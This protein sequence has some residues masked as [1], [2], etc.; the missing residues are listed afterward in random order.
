MQSYLGGTASKGCCGVPPWDCPGTHGQLLCLP[1]PDRVDV[2]KEADEARSGRAPEPVG[3]GTPA[4]GL[5]SV[6][7]SIADRRFSVRPARGHLC[8]Q[9]GPH[10]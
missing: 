3:G 8:T 5:G 2:Q 6:F 1:F 10:R 9:E 4:R 7:D